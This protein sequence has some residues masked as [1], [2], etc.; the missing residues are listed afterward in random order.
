MRP[1]P[2]QELRMGREAEIILR[3]KI[4]AGGQIA[5]IITNR[6]ARRRA[7]LGRTGK[8][9]GAR[10]AA[11]V[12]PGLESLAATQQISSLHDAEIPHAAA[13]R[14]L[15]NAVNCS[16]RFNIALPLLVVGR[17]CR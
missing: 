15:R 7:C 5:A 10:L 12:L 4:D 9:P 3:G 8:R 13:Q 17:S 6:T 2:Q 16:V 11:G 1:W 14:C